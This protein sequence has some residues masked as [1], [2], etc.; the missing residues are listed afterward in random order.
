[1][2]HANEERCCYFIFCRFTTQP[3]ILLFWFLL[4]PKATQPLRS[5]R[6]TEYM[7]KIDKLQHQNNNTVVYHEWRAHAHFLVLE[8]NR[9]RKS[10]E[11]KFLHTI[12]ILLHSPKKI[13]NANYINNKCYVDQKPNW[14]GKKVVAVRKIDVFLKMSTLIKYVRAKKRAAEFPTN[15]SIVQPKGGGGCIYYNNHNC[16]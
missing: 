8:S 6:P 7:I 1:M 11:H 2:N 15:N 4:F 3:L 5:T 10:L 12:A 16:I 9:A 13:S 14:T